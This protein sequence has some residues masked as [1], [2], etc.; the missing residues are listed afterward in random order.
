MAN[1]DVGIIFMGTSEYAIPVLRRLV[2]ADYD[3]RLVVTQPNRPQGRKRRLLPPPV[4]QIADEMGLPVYQ[5]EKIRRETCYEILETRHPDL[6][7]TASYGQILRQKHLDIPKR[8]ILNV[9][10]SLL[11]EFRGAAPIQHAVLDGRAVT[12]V[13]IM[14]TDIG[15]DTGPILSQAT[16]RIEADDTA[17]TLEAKLASLGADLLIDTLPGYLAGTIQPR[18]QDPQ[19]ATYAPRITVEDGRIDWSQPADCIARRV[20]AM[21]PWPCTY[22]TCHGQRLKIYSAEAE[23]NGG[24]EALPGTIVNVVNGRGI[25]VQTGCGVLL[26]REL[27][28]ACRKRMPGDNLVRGRFAETGNVLGSTPES[29]PLTCLE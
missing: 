24:T 14:K 7:V 10:A 16:C 2:E 18:A 15:I 1:R 12:G 17:G 5:P 20:R 29:E 3:I 22:T 28:P 9:H 6:I 27:Q 25:Q 4:R 11:P 8:G 26:V 21:N 19:R 23:E 13:T